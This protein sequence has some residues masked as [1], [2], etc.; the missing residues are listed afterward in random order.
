MDKLEDLE[1]LEKEE[2]LLNQEKEGLMEAEEQL[3]TRISVEIEN[4]RQK[5]K[6]L[7]QEVEQRRRKCEDLTKILNKCNIS[8]L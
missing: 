7:K 5:N 3:W 1:R 8:Q 4:K 2:D 6:Q